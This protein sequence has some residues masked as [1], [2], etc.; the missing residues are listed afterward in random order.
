MQTYEATSAEVAKAEYAV[1]LSSRMY[2][3]LQHRL[4]ASVPSEAVL[5]SPR[6]AQ[7]AQEADELSSKDAGPLT[8]LKRNQDFVRS[9]GV[10]EMS[11]CD[12]TQ[13]C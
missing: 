7:A 4:T 3:D 12:L 9:C 6:I 8:T 10:H 5:T 2:Q 1:Q 11:D 13:L